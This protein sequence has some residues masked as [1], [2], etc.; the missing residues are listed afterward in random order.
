MLT[1]TWP[2]SLALGAVVLSAYVQTLCPT[3]PYGDSGELIQV[4]IEGGVVHPPGYP[5]WTMLANAF[6]RLPY[7]EPA[8][9]INLSSAVCGALAAT[10]L[11]AAVGLWTAC[12]WTGVAA[13][14]AFAFAPLVWEYSVQGEVFALNNLNNAL[15][16]YLLVRFEQRPTLPRACAGAFMIGLALCNQHTLI[17]YC[18]PYALWALGVCAHARLLTPRALGM[19]ALSGLAGLSPYLYLPFA[20]GVHAAWGSWGDQRSLSGLLT[21]FLRRDYGTFQLANTQATTNDDYVPRLHRYI[22]SVP[23]ELPPLGA[24]LLILG[25]V[26]SVGQSL[27]GRSQNAPP[28]KSSSAAATGGVGEGGGSV[29]GAATSSVESVAAAGEEELVLEDNLDFTP[30]SAS[31]PTPAPAPAPAIKGAMRKVPIEDT[32]GDED[33]GEQAEAAS[34]SRVGHVSFGEDTVTVLKPVVKEKAAT[35]HK[36]A[37]KPSATPAVKTD[38]GGVSAGNATALPPSAARGVSHG[39]GLLLPIAYVFYL[40]L[41]NY[42]SNLPVD[43]AF[44]LQVQQRFWPQAHLLCAVW[45]AIGLKHVVAALVTHGLGGEPMHD[46]GAATTRQRHASRGGAI[47]NT[48]SSALA[49]IAMPLA[50]AGLALHH[51]RTHHAKSD[52]SQLTLFRDFGIEVLR[53]LPKAKRVVLL[54]LGD[55]VLN[56]VRY[57]QRQ[58][59]HAPDVA[60]LD[61]N[62]MQFEWWVDR[63][64]ANAGA[65]GLDGFKFPG[66]HYGGADDAFIMATLLDANYKDWKFFVCGGMHANDHSWE[67]GYRLWPLGMTMQVLK[68]CGAPPPRHPKLTWPRASPSPSHGPV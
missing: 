55:E 36:A 35:K 11:S 20:S 62:Y 22:T 7:G 1:T 47:R 17:F 5:T 42:L 8:W 16:L 6:S 39:L 15:L 24:P 21:H 18:V 32:T 67:A 59:G 58:L 19:L 57:A 25:F 66:R 4:A 23:A 44:Y 68:R 9:R 2:L 13:G 61:L 31:A 48:A 28:E 54:T 43:S 51:A 65:W 45:Y 12:P 40:L 37:R 34:K 60:V 14:G 50:A 63:A 56:S 52:L 53:T 33:D 10:L 3:V 49:A 30:A 27:S 64:K 26:I 46:A 41:F 38:A 29:G